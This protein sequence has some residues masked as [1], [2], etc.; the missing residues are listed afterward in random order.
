MPTLETLD[1]TYQFY[2]FKGEPGTR[3]STAALSFPTPQYWFSWDKKMQSM[4]V[5]MMNWGIN[6]NEVQYDDYGNWDDA[7]KKLE[8]LQISSNFKVNGKKIE[9]VIIDSMTSAMDM[10]IRQVSKI[11][12]QSG[13]GK[14]IAGIP[15]AGFEEFNA[16]S[17]AGN[18]MIALLKDIQTNHKCNIILIAHVMEVSGKTPGGETVMSRSIVTAA[19]RLAAKIPGYCS[20]VYHFDIESS[21]SASVPGD[22]TIITEHT[23]DDFARTGL[24]LPRRWKMNAKPLY[25][26]LLL[27]AIEELKAKKIQMIKV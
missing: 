16:E 22:Y 21:I 26:D 25:K 5:P 27:P 4:L 1:P 23:G 3:K 17:S 13:D 8:S 20:E 15:V 6:V 2:M 12:G 14:K 19:K 10:T 7:R 11:K 18:E 9:T 24:N